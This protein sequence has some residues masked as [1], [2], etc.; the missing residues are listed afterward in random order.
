VT[1]LQ[2][3]DLSKNFGGLRVL[4]KVSF[5]VEPGEKLALI[6]PNGA[7]KTTLINVIGGQLSASAG[8][9]YLGGKPVTR[10]PANKRLKLGLGRS[11]QVNNLFFELSVLDNV[12]LAL[13]GA[14]KSHFHMLGKLEKRPGLMAEAERLLS[15]VALWERRKEPLHVLSYGDQRLVELLSAFTSRPQVV[16]LDEP[17]AGLPT[18]EA[19]A[20]A[21]IIRR[22]SGDTTLLFCAHD[23]DLVFNLADRIMV[24]YFG[25]IIA[26]GLP[27]DISANPRVQEIYLGSEDETC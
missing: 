22:L 7:G 11:Y 27:K 15:L 1:V 20:F 17:S 5:A 8:Q 23:M 4:N 2:V 3:E 21:D 19:F 18:A 25:E 13:Y 9:V 16:L 24:L 14:E 12:L 6:G 26:S 10:L